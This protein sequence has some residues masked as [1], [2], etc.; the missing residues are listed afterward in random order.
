[1]DPHLP[2]FTITA[3]EFREFLAVWDASPNHDH[4]YYDDAGFDLD[5][6]DR[7]AMPDDMVLDLSGAFVAYQGPGSPDPKHPIFPM[8][9]QREF[10]PLSEVIKKWRKASGTEVLVIT[11]TREMA[12]EIRRYAAGLGA[13]I[14]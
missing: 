9:S 1:M 13:K 5:P 7:I 6:A 12:A 4:Y 8:S 2:K 11:G 14:S 10:L 3:A